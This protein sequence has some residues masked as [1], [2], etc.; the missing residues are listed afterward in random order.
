MS[1]DTPWKAEG[2]MICIPGEYGACVC[3]M[4]EPGTDTV[5]HLPVALSS[6][7]F[8]ESMAYRDLI[9]LAVNSHKDLLGA[10]KALLA[11]VQALRHFDTTASA[12]LLADCRAAIAKAGG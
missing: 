7:R 9:V 8:K 4:S 11:D 6:M 5:E 2:R 3:E 10:L 12:N 1:K